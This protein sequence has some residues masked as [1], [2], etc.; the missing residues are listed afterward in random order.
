VSSLRVTYRSAPRVVSIVPEIVWSAGAL[1]ASLLALI[2]SGAVVLLMM[3]L[4]RL[5][6]LSQ[7]WDG[8]VIGQSL[9]LRERTAKTTH[10]D[11]WSDPDEDMSRSSDTF[12]L[13]LNEQFLT[14]AV[15][16][17]PKAFALAP[18]CSL[19]KAPPAPERCWS[20]NQMGQEGLFG[21]P[22]S[23]SRLFKIIQDY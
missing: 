21:L 15:E 7:K 5:A 11:F 13:S 6:D 10:R 16:H 2:V 19:P 14:A 22:E 18:S 4:F 17:R 20:R 9:L 23:Y 3:C 8:D 1:F 12:V